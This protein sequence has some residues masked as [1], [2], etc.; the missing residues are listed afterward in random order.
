MLQFKIRNYRAA[1][2]VDIVLDQITAIFGKNDAGKTSS[3]DAIRSV[4]TGNPNPFSKEIPKK[5][6][7]M[8][9]RSGNPSGFV[10]MKDGKTSARVDWPPCE[11]KSGSGIP[12]V[13]SD[14]S[15]GLESLADMKTKDRIKKITDIT[16]AAPTARDLADELLTNGIID[17]GVNNCGTKKCDTAKCDIEGCAYK[18]DLFKRLW[19]IIDVNDWDIAHEMAQKKGAKLKGRWEHAT[20]APKY[21][22]RIAEQWLPETWTID[23][24]KTTEA[25][26][27][28]E[29]GKAREWRDS[30]I[31]ETAVAETELEALKLKAGNVEKIETRMKVLT[32]SQEATEKERKKKIAELQDI[33]SQLNTVV[34]D[35]PGCEKKLI[36][37]NN[38][39]V[40]YKKGNL[41]KAE[42]EK[43]KVP[44]NDA[45]K[46]LKLQG[47]TILMDYGKC[48][49]DL[50]EAKAAVERLQN[51]IETAEESEKNLD[52]VENRLNLAIDR[53]S[54]YRAYHEAK[55][56]CDDIAGNKTI[57]AI[58]APGGLRNKKLQSEFKVFNNSMKF[59]TDSVKWKE[60]EITES[61]DILAG[62]VPFGRLLA[63][64][65]RYRVRVLLQLMVAMAE[66]S[67]FVIIDDSDE[68]TASIRR[69]LFAILMKS[70]IR[71][72]VVSALDS[73]EEMKTPVIEGYNAYWIEDGIVEAGSTEAGKEKV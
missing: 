34:F 49:G 57:Q 53:L 12:P 44:I 35:C 27:I 47:D 17:Y 59:L 55:R 31:A 7:S 37:S 32:K 15:A 42:L 21:G 20:G 46:A 29:E 11:Y 24:E 14:I 4:A 39:L 58:L 18:I 38:K 10:E 43:K 52:D 36:I 60:V 72:I 68:L 41:N 8:L 3:L 62:G 71:A 70:T 66:K 26:L 64:S 6:A 56:L 50:T 30:A 2:K 54:A 63:K 69:G 25:K 51:P 22:I 33:E 40:E 23:L 48:R 16:G 73:R 65:T 45:I 5:F 67:A 19:E 28:D 13:I 61:G 1:E 9:V